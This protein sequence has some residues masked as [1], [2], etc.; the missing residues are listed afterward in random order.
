MGANKP[1]T[2]QRAG[3]AIGSVHHLCLAFEEDTTG[4]SYSDKH[5]FPSFRKDF[6]NNIEVNIDAG[7]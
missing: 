1:V 3:K 5:P 6:E 4:H 2:A 7:C